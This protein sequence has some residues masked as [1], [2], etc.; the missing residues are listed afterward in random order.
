VI[1]ALVTPTRPPANLSA[2]MAQAQAAIQAES[3]AG[4][5]RA[6]RSPSEHLLREMDAIHD[7]IES[8]ASKLLRSIEPWSSYAVLPL[9]ALANAGFVWSSGIL[10]GHG[11]MV[12]AIV[13][14]LAVGKPVGIFAGAWLAVRSGI[15]TKPATYGWRQLAGAG[16]LAGIGF[17][18]SLF[19]AGQAFPDPADFAAAKVAIYLA[20]L[21]SGA[22]G[23]TILWRRGGTPSSETER[24]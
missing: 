2:L 8:P 6:R 20:S 10:D 11:R 21:I 17:T 22:A 19:I 13:L 5:G 16:A 14:G 1:L 3:P 24:Q 18:M 15:A 23:L 9:F 12:L 7:R 4:G